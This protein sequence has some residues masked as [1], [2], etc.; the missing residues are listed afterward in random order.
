MRSAKR[1]E[2]AAESTASGGAVKPDAGGTTQIQFS[3]LIKQGALSSDF[4]GAG[5]FTRN[6]DTCS[7]TPFLTGAGQLIS[8]DDPRSIYLK[9]KFASQRG[10]LGLGMWDIHG[11]TKDF[12]LLKAAKEGLSFASAGAKT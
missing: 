2:P 7:G 1:Q 9:G 10:M 3:S 8:Y 12:A 5:G 11:D 6:W 4:K